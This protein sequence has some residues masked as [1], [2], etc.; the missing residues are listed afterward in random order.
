M[1]VRSEN[2]V[3]QRFTNCPNTPYTFSRKSE[4]EELRNPLSPYATSTECHG[5]ILLGS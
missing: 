3:V 2:D 1:G 4:I 5:S